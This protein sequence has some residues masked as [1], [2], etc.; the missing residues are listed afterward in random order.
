MIHRRRL[1][2]TAITAGGWSL[3]DDRTDG[4]EVAPR[5]GKIIDT[6]LSLHLWPFRRL[7]LDRT[8]DLVAKLREL[9][10]AQAW[11]ASF[12]GIL[13]RDLTAVNQRVA[14][15]CGQYDELIPI[16][17]INPALPGW[18]RDLQLCL[19]RHRMPGVRLYPNYHG[20]RIDHPHCIALL[21]QT[22][23]T[24]RF[25]QIAAQLED[26]RTQHPLVQVP[27]VDLSLLPAVL[28]QCRGARVQILNTRLTGTLARQLAGTAGIYFDSSHID[29]TDG[30]ATL[31]TTIPIDRLLFGSQAPLLIPEAALIR[32]VENR[33]GDGRLNQLLWQNAEAFAG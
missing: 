25:V 31:S 20:Y 14:D 30:I 11:A 19:G 1:L 15:T 2:G 6:N 3:L 10:V 9:G 7:P 4:V 18:E 22:A 21:R 16:G 26:P 24:N 5:I 29:G 23:A 28:Q 8:A 12:D 17:T 33:L 27:H 32:A 13:H